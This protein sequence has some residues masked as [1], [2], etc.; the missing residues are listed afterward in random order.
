MDMCPSMFWQMVLSPYAVCVQK[1]I[2]IFNYN[3]TLNFTSQN[4][5]I[6]K[7][8]W[9]ADH[10]INPW[11]WLVPGLHES[12]TYWKFLNFKMSF[13]I[14]IEIQNQFLTIFNE[15]KYKN[16]KIILIFII[17]QFKDKDFE[18][19][20]ITSSNKMWNALLIF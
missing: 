7:S 13:K 12:G 3:T 10:V 17:W 2:Y 15:L 5:N 11:T 14:Q 1:Y 19:Q 8:K 6:Y 16:L 20:D 9:M 18:K 4:K